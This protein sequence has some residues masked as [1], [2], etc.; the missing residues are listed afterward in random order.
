MA[1]LPEEAMAFGSF[2]A[3]SAFPIENHLGKLKRLIR[4]G[5][6]TQVFKRLV[7]MSKCMTSSNTMVFENLTLHH[8][9]K[10]DSNASVE[11]YVWL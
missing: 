4:S 1:H 11:D 9:V 3:C 8:G 5:T 2:D 7:E 10:I 6:L